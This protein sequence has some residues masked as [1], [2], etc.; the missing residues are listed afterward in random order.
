M[1]VLVLNI[2]ITVFSSLLVIVSLSI[3]LFLKV[4]L[5]VYFSVYACERNVGIELFDCW[6]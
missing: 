1:L 4:K 2:V 5:W 6:L 3:F